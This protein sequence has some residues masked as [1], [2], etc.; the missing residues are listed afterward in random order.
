MIAT[1]FRRLRL[2]PATL[3]AAPAIALAQPPAPPATET[4]VV[5]GPTF[6]SGVDLIRLDVTVVGKDGSPVADLNS[7]DFEVRVGGKLRPVA[8]SRF[9]S[10]QPRALDVVAGTSLAS[11]RDYTGNDAGHSGRLFVFA[12]DH[13]SL[14]SGAGRPLMMAA[15]KLLDRLGTSDRVAL[16]AVPQPGQRVEFTDDI[17]DVVRGLGRIT[18]RRQSRVRTVRVNFDEATGFEQRNQIVMDDVFDRE[19]R[20]RSLDATCVEQLAQ[21]AQDVL[22][23]TRERTTTTLTHLSGLFD[24]LIGIDG[25]KTVIFF[26]AG[27]GFEPRMLNRFQEVSKRAIEARLTLYVVQVDSFAFDTTE[28]AS[29]A[30]FMGDQDAGMKGLGTLTGMTGGVLFRGVAEGKGVWDR[31]E[32]ESG[33]LYVLGVEPEAGSLPTEPLALSVKVKR[34]GLT[35]RTPQQVVPPRPLTTWPDPKRALGYTLR[36]PR[37]AS[38]LPI[39]VSAYTVRGS[40]DLRL[41]T[42]IAA[43]LALPVGQAMDLAWGFEVLD[44]GRVIADAFD[45]GLPHGSS[46][47][48]DGVMLVTAASLPAGNYTLRFA[49]MDNAGRRGS[50]DHSITV[51]LRMTHAGLG[52]KVTPERLYFSDLL[53]GQDVDDRF[54]PRLQFAADAG[55]ISALVEL[56]GGPQSGLDRATVEFDVRGLDGATRAATRITP[57]KAEGEFRSVAIAQL[58]VARLSPGSY[59]MHAKVLVDGRAV[60]LVRRQLTIT[61]GAMARAQ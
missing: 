26:S 25:P 30:A 15:A 52:D 43:E 5:Q 18:G 42:V 39:K 9:L 27:I 33:G 23:E 20:S 35:V 48:P 21:E 3:L 7:D 1:R 12:V 24:S 57:A 22:F 56:Y 2:L 38:E 55:T 41:K 8:T 44:K 47:T 17:Q 51:G 46:E 14:P 61:A 58:P 50:V 54:Q 60:G 19:C 31:I 49:A 10:L 32:R 11:T 45:R 34:P 16:V 40:A 53:I 4:P 59:E 29:S 13:E 6:K 28:R 36:Q 37:V